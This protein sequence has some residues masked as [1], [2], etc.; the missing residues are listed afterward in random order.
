MPGVIYLDNDLD[1]VIRGLRLAE[2]NSPINDAELYVALGRKLISGEITAASNATPIVV[3]SAAHGLSNGDS[4]VVMNVEGNLAA[5]GGWEV[6]NVTAN[7]F[8]LVGSVGSAAYL[9]GG[10]WYAGVTDAIHI[11]LENEP[12]EAGHYRGTIP[13]S[14][15]IDR[16]EMLV[17][18]IYC[19]NYQLGWQRELQGRI[20][21]R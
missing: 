9:A 20:R 19:R 15:N 8:E 1:I 2:D 18:L 17:E 14:I 7:T 13:G 4:V 3:T 21:T 11:P 12:G 6:A 5:N 10:E 16:S